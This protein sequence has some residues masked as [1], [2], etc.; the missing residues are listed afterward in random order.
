MKHANHMLT[1]IAPGGNARTAQN[2]TMKN[3]A[4]RV[5]LTGLLIGACLLVLSLWSQLSAPA[6]EWMGN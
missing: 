3:I 6:M 4:T 2:T 5:L 1:S